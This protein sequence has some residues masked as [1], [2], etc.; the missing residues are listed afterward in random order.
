MCPGAPVLAGL[1]PESMVRE[2]GT[3][4]A[5]GS[6]E[7]AGPPYLVGTVGTPRARGTFRDP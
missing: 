1:A 4:G 7:E 3:E 6:E 5:W 2:P